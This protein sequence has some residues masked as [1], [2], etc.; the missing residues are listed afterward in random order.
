MPMRLRVKPVIGRGRREAASSRSVA[1]AQ[2]PGGS[3]RRLELGRWSIAERGV[4]A[5]LVVDLLDEG[6]DAARGFMVIAIEPAIDLLGLERLHEALG[7]GV[8]VGIADPAH[9]GDNAARLEQLGVVA[10]GILGRFKRSSQHGL[11]GLIEGTGQA[12]LRAFAKQ[13]SCEAWR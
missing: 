13:A 4:Q 5:L 9:A 2:P 11:C 6:A 8:V 7:L 3:M 1:H 12:P 10:T